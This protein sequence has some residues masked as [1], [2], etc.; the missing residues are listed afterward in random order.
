MSMKPIPISETEFEEQ[1]LHADGLVIVNFW[2][3]W[4]RPSRIVLPM[5]D[6]VAARQIGGLK[7]VLVNVDKNHK[8]TKTFGI[9]R[10]PTIL[11]F[12]AGKVVDKAEG[13]SSIKYLQERIQRLMGSPAFVK[14]LA[15]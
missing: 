3:P 6:A 8:A 9:E 11:F 12:M 2:A 13:I 4:S 1:V 14:N 10:I 5:L 7:L 15:S